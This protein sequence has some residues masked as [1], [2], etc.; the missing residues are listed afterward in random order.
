M[1]DWPSII[2]Q[3]K[4]YGTGDHFKEYLIGVLRIFVMLS[5]NKPF[6]AKTLTQFRQLLECA[7]TF[8]WYFVD[9]QNIS[10]VSCWY[11]ENCDP[12]CIF[13]DDSEELTVLHLIKSICYMVKRGTNSTD[14]TADDVFHKQNTYVGVVVTIVTRAISKRQVSLKKLDLV[15]GKL[16]SDIDH[17]ANIS[18]DQQFIELYSSVLALL[19]SAAEGPMLQCIEC[20]IE[21][22][23]SEASSVSAVLCIL[24]AA[25]RVLAGL[26]QLLTLSEAAIEC[27]FNRISDM[28]F[29][30]SWTRI[31]E[32]FLVPELNQDQFIR[33]AL[34]RQCLLTLYA[35]NLH[36]ISLCRDSTEEL[37][38][39]KETFLWCTQ[40]V[41]SS[42]LCEKYLMMWWQI[43][44]SVKR[45]ISTHPRQSKPST[46]TSQVRQQLIKFAGY[47]QQI[48]EDKTYS[49]ILGAI[50]VGKKSQFPVK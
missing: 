6:M 5:T 43:L 46:V 44:E 25:C 50:G 28:D 8:P 13:E 39:L 2:A 35:F 34:S 11:A 3:Q 41:P 24:S 31:L 18:S 49:G 27:F 7:S 17:I 14:E 42:N 9:L 32:V 33:K 26:D 29:D 37:P 21:K 4:K 10:A 45:Q 48:G 16:L 20:R 40:S 22:F 1:L 19:N 23:L 30:E 38:I 36:R 47:C 12:G 15:F